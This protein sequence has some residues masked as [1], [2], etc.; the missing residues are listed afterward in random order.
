M[1]R[2]SS[3]TQKQQQQTAV[4]AN[5][6]TNAKPDPA[7]LKPAAIDNPLGSTPIRSTNTEA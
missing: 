7:V 5:S 3:Q 1:K 2:L 4:A 6:S